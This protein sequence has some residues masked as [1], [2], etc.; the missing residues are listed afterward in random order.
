VVIGTEPAPLD[1]FSEE[2]LSPVITIYK[3]STF[4]EALEKI[5]GIT[6]R[7][8]R[9]HSMGIHTFKRE[10]IER[11][12][13]EM[14]TSR[15]TVRAPMAA[16]NGGHAANGMP[17]TATLGCGTWG[18]NATTEKH[19]LA[20]LHQ[21]DLGQRAQ[22]RPRSSTRRRSST[23]CGPVRQVAQRSSH[24]TLRISGQGKPLP[25]PASRCPRAG[26]P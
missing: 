17:S 26:G 9:G 16:A 25:P 8:G 13:Q 7:C 23:A 6:N 11:M 5:V 4:N 20:P 12:G 18:K 22:S 19:P 15:I 14:L 10:Y 24:E 21:R 3:Y 1:K 2:K